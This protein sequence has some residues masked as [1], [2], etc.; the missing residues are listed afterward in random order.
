MGFFYFGTYKKREEED[1]ALRFVRFRIGVFK[2]KKAT[3]AAVYGFPK[4]GSESGR[5]LPGLV[6]I[7][8]GGQYADYK[9]CLLNANRG[10]ATVSIAWAG[11][12]SAPDYRVTPVEFRELRWL[13]T[14]AAKSTQSLTHAAD[15]MDVT[16][17]V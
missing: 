7:H 16:D 15:E 3:L 4:N 10:H 13:L 6:Q 9:A 14:K 12:I 2:G 1:V 5:K 11:R 17:G 8:S